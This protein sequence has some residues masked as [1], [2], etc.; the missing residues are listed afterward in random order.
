MASTALF[1]NVLVIHI[2]LAGGLPPRLSSSLCLHGRAS[3]GLPQTM[4]ATSPRISLIGA[5]Y[6][7]PACPYQRR[8]A[9]P[10]GSRGLPEGA[11]IP[12]PAA[13]AIPSPAASS[14]CVLLSPIP[15]PWS[16]I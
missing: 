11:C 15:P 2:V 1:L 9:T 4:E 3:S 6:R 7:Y 14:K 5:F 10:L 16:R 8:V 12:Y 13:S